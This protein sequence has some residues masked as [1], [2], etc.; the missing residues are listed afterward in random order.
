M[1]NRT[2]R[3]VLALLLLTAAL[4]S[5]VPVASA[6]NEGQ[7]YEANYSRTKV[8]TVQVAATKYLSGANS[9]RDEMLGYGYD[10]FVYK[11]EGKYRIMCGKFRSNI[12]DSEPY[13][14]AQFYQG[15]ILKKTEYSDA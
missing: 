9:I 8:L 3:C 11:Y 13:K 6:F 15:E 2:L 14:Q 10:S 12:Y 7:Y 4:V 1:R 5:T